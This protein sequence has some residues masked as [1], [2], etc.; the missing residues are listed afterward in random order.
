M[1]ESNP[2]T[3]IIMSSTSATQATEAVDAHDQQEL[4]DPQA[5]ESQEEEE[6]QAET[7]NIQETH[8][9]AEASSEPVADSEIVN[10]TA[11]IVFE[12]HGEVILA[13]KCPNGD[14]ARFQVSSSVL[15]LASPVFRAML[16]L[17]SGFHEAV[18]LSK[19][20]ASKE[21][22]EIAFEDDD[23]NA[24]AVVL[25]ILHYKHYWIPKSLT[26]ERLY[27]VAIICDK[28]DLVQALETWLGRWTPTSFS[29]TITPDKWLFI[30]WVLGQE[31][32][33][34]RLSQALML[35]CN[36][37][38]NGNL[39]VTWKTKD[40]HGS[41]STEYIDINTYLP[42]PILGNYLYPVLCC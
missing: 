11:N 33:F 23:P 31:Q 12:S 8:P 37:D 25:R 22:L 14:Q 17:D 13:L 35:E 19:R 20:D 32:E 3:S 39:K 29:D 28:Y 2:E 18:V 15:C 1:A 40:E 21:P 38:D 16:S 26:P 6:Q 5:A 10:R 24:M 9:T 30:A 34:H 36:S 41:E 7:V 42:D 4:P 27:D